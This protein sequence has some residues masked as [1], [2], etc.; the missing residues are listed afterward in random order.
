MLRII[1]QMDLDF[2]KINCFV[3]PYEIAQR[4]N[5]EHISS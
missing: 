3:E 4:V 2:V 1:K 5:V